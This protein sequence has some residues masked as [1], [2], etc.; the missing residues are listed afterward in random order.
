[1]FHFHGFKTS[2]HVQAQGVNIRI[3]SLLFFLSSFNTL[4]AV[5]NNDEATRG[6]GAGGAAK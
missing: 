1:V 5:E 4:G 2:L 3:F 6:A